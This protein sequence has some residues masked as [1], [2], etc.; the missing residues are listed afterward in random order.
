MPGALLF[1]LSGALR[2]PGT[3][4][5]QH[6]ESFQESGG[7]WKGCWVFRCGFKSGLQGVRD[8]PTSTWALLRRGLW[9]IRETQWQRG[10]HHTPGDRRRLWCVASRVRPLGDSAAP[11]CGPLVASGAGLLASQ[12]LKQL[13]SLQALPPSSPECLQP[14]HPS[15]VPG[16]DRVPPRASTH[17]FLLPR[18]PSSALRC[19]LRPPAAAP[20]AGL[21]LLSM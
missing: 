9:I 15:P 7:V 2:W 12:A 5:C 16:P 20:C 19:F 10:C 14:T 3:G 8:G 21:S 13:S 4:S 17:S 11:R 1:L 6:Q 18:S